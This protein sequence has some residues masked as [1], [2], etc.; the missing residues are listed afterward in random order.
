MS[1]RKGVVFSQLWR[2]S[3]G[4]WGD[5]SKSKTSD[6]QRKVENQVSDHIVVALHVANII[7]HAA[8]IIKFCKSYKLSAWVQ[9]M[10]AQN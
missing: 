5:W 1:S 9:V 4:H 8:K 7:I 10:V 3:I 2:S 6:L